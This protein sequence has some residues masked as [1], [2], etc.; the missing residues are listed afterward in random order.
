MPP[1]R[2]VRP[3]E[4]GNEQAQW[5]G[6]PFS[7]AGSFPPAVQS[8]AAASMARNMVTVEAGGAFQQWLSHFGTARVQLTR[9]NPENLA[10]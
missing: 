4:E 9:Q 2:Q 1:P 10:V 8:D 5:P 6:M 7:Q 3:A